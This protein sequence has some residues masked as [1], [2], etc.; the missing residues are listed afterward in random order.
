MKLIT[1]VKFSNSKFDTD[2]VQLSFH[3]F[4]LILTNFKLFFCYFNGSSS[5]KED[6]QM[7][8]LKYK[9]KIMENVYGGDWF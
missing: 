6:L 9:E 1:T 4:D 8:V 7:L 5:R 3:I 2:D